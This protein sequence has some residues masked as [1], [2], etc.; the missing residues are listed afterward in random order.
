M[1]RIALVVLLL[2]IPLG[3][4]VLRANRPPDAPPLT[5]HALRA[6]AVGCYALLT[7]R[8]RRVDTTYYNASPVVRLDSGRAGPALANNQGIWPVVAL[9]TLGRPSRT[10]RG[11]LSPSW[12][13]DSLSDSVRI[14]F[15]NGFSGAE[16]VF[17]LPQRGGDTLHGRAEESWDFRPSATD[18][19]SA[20]AVRVV[21]PHPDISARAG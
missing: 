2:A 12:S 3:W 9:D 17:A 10:T 1:K 6:D 11:R 20:H 16:F 18:R 5:R 21:C 7:D 8:W 4:F 13:A 19:G 14:S 15:V